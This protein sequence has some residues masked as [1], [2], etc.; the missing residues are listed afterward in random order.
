VFWIS[1]SFGEILAFLKTT[2]SAFLV[3]IAQDR[4]L[5]FPSEQHPI[6]LQIGGNNLDNIAKATQLANAYGFDEINLK[7]VEFSAFLLILLLF[8]L[9]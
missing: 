3:Y 8:F 9:G 2:N 6:V 5:A 4:F 1:P 7:L